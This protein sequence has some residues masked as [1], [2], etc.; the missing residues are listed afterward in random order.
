MA[1]DHFSGGAVDYAKFR[2]GYPEAL[3]DWIAAQTAGHDLVWDCGCGS[4]QASVPLA[5]RYRRVVAT[6]LS[7]RQIREAAPH[8]RVAYRAAPA[9]AS[10]LP[11][12]CCDLVTVAQALHW[13]DFDRFY[14]E[15]RR[16]LK[17]GGVLA[18]W[19]YQL[20]RGEPG[21]DEIFIDYY[22]RVLASWWPAERKWVD[23][24]YRT[25]PFPFEEIAAP[26]L[27]IR[28]Q[29]T[30]DDLL[31]YLRTW[32]ATRYLAQAESRDP[33]LPLGDALR[34]VWGEGTREIVWP[35]AMRVGRA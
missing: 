27:E 11:D 21:I 31:A 28:L 9:E 24:S 23:E 4:G 3:F 15:V 7:E 19:T 29:W 5:E 18:A 26:S 17:P 35:I 20:L 30:L 34:P 16:V 25:L 10:G 1:A 2:P 6:D 8:P 13:F 14:A 12:R 33:T 32:T 22:R